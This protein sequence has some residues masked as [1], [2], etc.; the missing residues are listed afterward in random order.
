MC[1]T[2][3]E[4]DTAPPPVTACAWRGSLAKLPRLWL[5]ARPRP[6]AGEGALLGEADRDEMPSGE[7][8]GEGERLPGP[9]R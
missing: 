1:D 8:V 3:R 5:W 9:T 7:W 2:D 4:V 6:R